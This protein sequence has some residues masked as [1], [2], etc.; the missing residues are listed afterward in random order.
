MEQ[1][2][3]GEFVPAGLAGMA[4]G[5]QLVAVL[6]HVDMDQVSDSDLVAVLAASER[7]ASWAYEI[8]ARASAQVADRVARAACRAGRKDCGY[9]RS[10]AAAQEVALAVGCSR[11]SAAR[12]V[13]QGRALAGVIPAVATELRAGRLPAGH[14]KV[15]ADR[16]GDESV[17]VCDAVL[18]VVLPGACELTP[19]ALGVAVDKALHEVDPDRAL[20]DQRA[21]SWRRVG[22]PCP[23]GQGMASLTAV[24]P[25]VDAAR[26]DKTLEQVARAARSAGDQRTI[27]E[28]RADIMVDG[29]TGDTKTN[30]DAHGAS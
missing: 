2:V 4:P 29:L 1:C 9:G 17:P 5:P 3:Q 12:L 20:V 30:P 26:V 8:S 18:G 7:M 14:A 24:L 25:A 28:L 6:E 13:S 15:L 21:R 23:L 16:L 19:R 11:G 10:S 27:N 22:N